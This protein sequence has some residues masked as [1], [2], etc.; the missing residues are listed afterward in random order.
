MT[1]QKYAIKETLE[2]ITGLREIGMLAKRLMA[3]G[4]ISLGDF[5]LLL[6]LLN[7]NQVLNDAVK[8]IDTAL[9][10]VKE[11]DADEAKQLVAAMFQAVAD[12]KNA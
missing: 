5:P 7:K 4:K 10:E 3:D 9:L 2:L 12:I 11:L 8:G 1:E 6:A